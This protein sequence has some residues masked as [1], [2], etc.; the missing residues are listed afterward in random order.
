MKRLFKLIQKRFLNKRRVILSEYLGDERVSLIDVGA[1]GGLEQ[2]WDNVADSIIVY[3]FEPDE[4]SANLEINK[5]G[6]INIINKA[7]WKEECE[8]GIFHTNKP[9]CSSVFQPNRTYLELFPDVERFNIKYQKTYPAITLGS[10]IDDKIRDPDF[11]K[12]DAQG[13]ELDII[14]GAGDRLNSVLG[15]EVEIEFKSIYLGQPL[16][17]DVHNYLED[18]DFSFVDFVSLNRWERHAHN[19]MGECNFGDGLFLKTPE[20][21]FRMYKSGNIDTGKMRRY[22]AILFIYNRYDLLKVF[23]EYLSAVSQEE[24]SRLKSLLRT[25]EVAR[26]AI[27]FTSKISSNIISLLGVNAKSHILY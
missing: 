19:D 9:F 12:L 3:G 18:N 10:V 20:N 13:A 2:R 1:A 17:S 15:V 25:L 22:C 27:Y 24:T 23:S 8:L 4:R 5:S 16:F 26:R 21:V 11:I 6:N 14:K 7:L